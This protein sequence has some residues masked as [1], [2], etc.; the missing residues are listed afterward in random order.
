MGK[1]II[2][3]AGNGIDLDVVTAGGNDIRL[4]KVIVDRNGN[5]VTG[6]IGSRNG[7]KITPSKY[8]QS[9]NCTGKIMNGD[10]VVEGIPDALIGQK[11]NY[12]KAVK[13]LIPSHDFTGFGESGTM[14]LA[15]IPE[16]QLAIYMLGYVPMVLGSNEE[17]ILDQ[18]TMDWI[19]LRRT[20]VGIAIEYQLSRP[21]T[22][23]GFTV[24]GIPF[25]LG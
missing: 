4:G 9:V 11:S 5:A 8:E 22:M 21:Y 2:M 25:E 3:N 18:G 14:V 7:A 19:V 16:N 15:G 24:Y 17:K 13:Y 1:G 23:S 10:I 12:G 20:P 6:K